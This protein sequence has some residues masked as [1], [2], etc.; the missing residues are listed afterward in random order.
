MGRMSR[1]REVNLLSQD[2]AQEQFRAIVL[3]IVEERLGS[4]CST[5]WPHP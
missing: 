2:L 3:R 5:I 1:V 4:F